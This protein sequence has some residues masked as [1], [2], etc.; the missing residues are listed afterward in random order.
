MSLCYMIEYMV[1]GRGGYLCVCV[2][3]LCILIATWLNSSH[4]NYDGA[5]MKG[6]LVHVRTCM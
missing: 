3:N 1:I 5:Q 6:V 2:D 4:I